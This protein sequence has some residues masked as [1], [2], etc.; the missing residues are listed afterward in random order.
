MIWCD[1]YDK[2]VENLKDLPWAYQDCEDI[3]AFLP[4]LGFKDEEIVEVG[5]PFKEEI[6][7]AWFDHV[8]NKIDPLRRDGKKM[9]VFVYYAGHGCINVRGQ[10]CICL[11][12]SN[13]L[14]N[15]FNLE[16]KIRAVGKASQ[17][18]ILGLFDCCRIQ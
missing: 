7:K 2:S 5:N 10:T 8:E 13:S 1:K 18:Y 16:E 11:N 6:K 4:K 17:I 15:I 12:D 3:K 9:F 14:L